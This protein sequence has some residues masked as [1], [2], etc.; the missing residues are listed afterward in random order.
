MIFISSNQFYFLDKPS[1]NILV[2]CNPYAGPRHS[3]NTYNTKVK[4]MLERAH[5]KITYLC[6]SR[7]QKKNLIKD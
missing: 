4:S 6:K 5:Y 2:I 3:R 1:R 7:K